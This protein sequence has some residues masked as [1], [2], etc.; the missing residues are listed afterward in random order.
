[1]S[2]T[3]KFGEQNGAERR[4]HL[5]KCASLF[6]FSLARNYYSLLVAAVK[7]YDFTYQIFCIIFQYF[8]YI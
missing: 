1:M 2:P 7:F 8:M 6:F 4:M 3:P 5:T